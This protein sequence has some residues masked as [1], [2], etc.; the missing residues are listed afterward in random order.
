MNMNKRKIL[1]KAGKYCKGLRKELK[2]TQTYLAKELNTSQVNISR[3]ENGK[4]DSLYLFVKY[5]SYYKNNKRR[6]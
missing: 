6:P 3:F 5:V 1:K 4:N 2:L